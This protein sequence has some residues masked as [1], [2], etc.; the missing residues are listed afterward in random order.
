MRNKVAID[1][2]EN[3]RNFERKI[4]K[5][6]LARG[7]GRSAEVYRDGIWAMFRKEGSD[8]GGLT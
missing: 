2:R 7:M 1:F 6:V 3:T 5:A 4:T 8:Q